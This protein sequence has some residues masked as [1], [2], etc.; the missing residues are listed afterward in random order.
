[1]YRPVRLTLS[2]N[3]TDWADGRAQEDYGGAEPELLVGQ[4]QKS[5]S[6]HARLTASTITVFTLL[7]RG[8]ANSIYYHEAHDLTRSCVPLN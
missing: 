5:K 2:Y 4:K 7:P 1:M 3:V 6:K 8:I